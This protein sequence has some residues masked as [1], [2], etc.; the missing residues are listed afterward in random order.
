MVIGRILEGRKNRYHDRGNYHEAAACCKDC[1][2]LSISK[3]I[4]V[5]LSSNRHSNM[6][7]FNYFIILI[8]FIPQLYMEYTYI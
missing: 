4:L 5:S 6:K 7:T 3:L 1:S 8:D 2:P